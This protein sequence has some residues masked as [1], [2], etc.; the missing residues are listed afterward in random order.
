MKSEKCKCKRKTMLVAP[1]QVDQE[2]RKPR[3]EQPGKKTLE[4]SLELTE[5]WLHIKITENIETFW[6]G[7]TLDQQQPQERKK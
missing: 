2:G 6:K 3:A 1:V 4:F 5:E 7:L